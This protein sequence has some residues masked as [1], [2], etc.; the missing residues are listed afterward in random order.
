MSSRRF[1]GL[2]SWLLWYPTSMR[3]FALKFDIVLYIKN[4]RRK[5]VE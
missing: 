3:L 4:L 2:E 5:A 1:S